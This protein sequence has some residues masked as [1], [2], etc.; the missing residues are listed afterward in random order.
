MENFEEA[1]AFVSE[2]K[3]GPAPGVLPEKMGHG[4]VEAV[5]AA[6]HVAGLD[7]DKHLEAA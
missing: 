5:E 4:V 7:G 3:K 2:G 6:S 1:A